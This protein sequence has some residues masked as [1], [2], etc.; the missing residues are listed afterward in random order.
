MCYLA[1]GFRAGYHNE[2]FEIMKGKTNEQ[3]MDIG[4]GQ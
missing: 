3:C 1:R 2:I 4:P